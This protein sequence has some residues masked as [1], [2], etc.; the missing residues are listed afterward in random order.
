MSVGSTHG[1][2]SKV[3]K[4]KIYQKLRGDKMAFE[5]TT[6][7]LLAVIL[8]ILVGIAYSLRRMFILERKLKETETKI[9][10]AL[11]KRKR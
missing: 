8:G 6:I 7:I 10:T 5:N 9:L 3:F 1:K 11:K 4:Y 2:K